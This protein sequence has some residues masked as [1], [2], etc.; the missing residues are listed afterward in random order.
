M[1]RPWEDIR[2]HYTIR[3]RDHPALQ[4]MARLIE[5]IQQSNLS[6]LYAWTSVNDL[7]IVPAPATYPYD[8]PRVRVSPRFNGTIELSYSAGDGSPKEPPQSLPE[9]DV[10]GP[11]QKL[12]NE[13][14]WIPSQT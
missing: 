14:S 6:R 2:R 10:F 3:P 8:G 13:L 9:D 7:L 12:A 1:V 11:L 4:A 5:Q